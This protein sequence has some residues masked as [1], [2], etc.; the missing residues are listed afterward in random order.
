M[1]LAPNSRYSGALGGLFKLVTLMPKA[2][3][4]MTQLPRETY[5]GGDTQTNQEGSYTRRQFKA[6]QGLFIQ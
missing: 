1:K 3:R 4:E 5:K 6:F 2:V